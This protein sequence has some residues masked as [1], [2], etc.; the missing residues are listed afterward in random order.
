MSI[1]DTDYS[2]YYVLTLSK[3]ESLYGHNDAN[4]LWTANIWFNGTS[5]TIFESASL[6]CFYE[7]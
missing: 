4:S 2:L 3:S 5:W 7:V 1:L 6:T